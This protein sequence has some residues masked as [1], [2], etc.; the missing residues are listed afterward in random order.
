MEIGA[1]HSRRVKRWNLEVLSSTRT[2]SKLRPG[3]GNPRQRRLQGGGAGFEGRVRK[4]NILEGCSQLLVKSMDPKMAWS[5][6]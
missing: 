6:G 2:P 5:F 1:W 3:G 4:V